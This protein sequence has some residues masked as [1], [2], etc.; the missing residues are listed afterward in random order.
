MIFYFSKYNAQSITGYVKGG[1]WLKYQNSSVAFDC[2]SEPLISNLK[3]LA[4]LS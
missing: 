3:W 2:A 4:I 1:E